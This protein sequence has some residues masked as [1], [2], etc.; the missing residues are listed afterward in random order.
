MT[1][2]RHGRDVLLVIAVTALLLGILV[3]L[4]G[5]GPGYRREDWAH[6]D[7]LPDSCQDVRTAV[8]LRDRVPGSEVL[9]RDARQCE[10]ARGTWVDPYTGDTIHDPL[11]LDVDHL[12]P[13]GEAYTSGGRSWSASQKRLY[14]NAQAFPGHLW[15]VSASQNRAKGDRRPDEWRPPRQAVWC[16][17]ALAWSAVKT[18]WGLRTVKAE[19]ETLQEMLA[20]CPPIQARTS[21]PPK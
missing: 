17:Y 19:R 1:L 16:D 5:A 18:S 14:A 2:P 13:L 20:T 15:A 12:V 6:W 10:L 7:R 11:K 8:L 3:L 21:E 4:T 9:W